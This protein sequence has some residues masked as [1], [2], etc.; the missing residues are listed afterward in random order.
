[1]EAAIMESQ[2]IDTAAPR[3]RQPAHHVTFKKRPLNTSAGK[4]LC[5][6]EVYVDGVLRGCLKQSS[7]QHDHL[8]LYNLA[9]ESIYHRDPNEPEYRFGRYLKTLPYAPSMRHLVI[10]AIGLGIFGTPEQQH[11]ANHRA[12]LIKL[13]AESKHIAT[14]AYIEAQPQI[15]EALREAHALLMQA[16]DSGD[17]GVSETLNLLA[18]A[19][20]AT[21]PVSE[22]HAHPMPGDAA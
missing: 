19:I 11:A 17:D 15:L 14:P 2:N 8:I 10:E 12:G 16:K 3:V 7:S 13:A 6:R 22:G 21:A 5:D 4:K 9:G 18:K 20:D 1:M